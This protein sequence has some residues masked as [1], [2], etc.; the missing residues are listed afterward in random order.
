MSHAK[1]VGPSFPAP[2]TSTPPSAPT[3]LPAASTPIALGDADLGGATRRA[4]GVGTTVAWVLVG[5]L[6]VALGVQYFAM[7]RPVQDDMRGTT[8][9]PEE[10]GANEREVLAASLVS[11]EAAL[12]SE[13][14]TV[15]L[16]ATKNASLAAQ[17]L[18]SQ[19]QHQV[20][21]N[22]VAS[23]AAALAQAQKRLELSLGAEIESGD[24]SV[25]KQGEDLVVGVDDRVLFDRGDAMLE[26]RGMKV[27]RRVAEVIRANPD[28][29][30]QIAGH[31]DDDP[32]TG[33]LATR[34]PTNWEL[35][36]ARATNV[37]RFLIEQCEVTP[38][39]LVAAG[40]AD[41]RPRA[42]NKNLRGKKKNR[43]I[44]ITLLATGAVE[45]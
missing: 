2:G 40:Y 1:P 16:L 24:V 21:A 27:L 11:T 9:Q 39:Q 20:L 7:H 28:K 32:V 13:R 43:R 45:K 35:S 25:R 6:G 5:A 44:E 38:K 37:V 17:L 4:T 36:T 31:T 26:D 18:A 34:F 15:Q 19:Q 33:Q 42:S 23:R 12:A 8:E 10:A 3:T 14:E 22:A 30:F 41:Q 29:Q